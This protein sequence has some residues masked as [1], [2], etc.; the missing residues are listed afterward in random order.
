MSTR[1]VLLAALLAACSRPAD[2]QPPASPDLK[3]EPALRPTLTARD[4]VGAEVLATMDPAVD[5]CVDSIATPAA[6]G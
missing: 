3:P 4:A 1:T 6:A 2:P 5:P